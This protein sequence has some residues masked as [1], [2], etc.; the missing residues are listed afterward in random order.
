M[1]MKQ[2]Q[3]IAR[4]DWQTPSARARLIHRETGL[5]IG[6][7]ARTPRGKRAQRN[8]GERLEGASSRGTR[9]ATMEIPWQSEISL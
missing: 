1:Y 3:S 7:Q 2:Q 6:R 5:Y 8:V 4:N 9:S